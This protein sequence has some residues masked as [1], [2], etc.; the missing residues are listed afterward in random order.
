MQE[1]D[2]KLP[3]LTVTH[4]YALDS[5]RGNIQIWIWGQFKLNDK[6]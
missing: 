3:P 6:I 2:E 1:N 4:K 5:E